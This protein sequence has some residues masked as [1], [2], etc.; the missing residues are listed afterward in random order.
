MTGTRGGPLQEMEPRSRA[1]L[2]PSGTAATW[3]LVPHSKSSWLV[4]GERV[5]HHG[6]Y[7]GAQQKGL[8]RSLVQ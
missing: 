1:V 5:H 4:L 3:S 6:R 7:V 2:Q 8:Q